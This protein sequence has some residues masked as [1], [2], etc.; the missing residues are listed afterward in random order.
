MNIR[1]KQA[2]KRKKRPSPI[3]R[4]TFIIILL[5]AAGFI[6]F[7]NI[8]N[9]NF[10]KNKFSSLLND[11][12]S[13]PAVSD[14]PETDTG[15]LSSSSSVEESVTGGDSDANEKEIEDD[16]EA[17]AGES[18]E[19][20]QTESGLSLWQKIRNFFTNQKDEKE[21]ESSYPNQLEVNFY[22]SADGNQTDAGM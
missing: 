11:S 1:N 22:F 3:L 21:N 15:Q 9:P 20:N 10:V 14:L 5:V 6:I 2:K 17:T 16:V 7:Y 13:E 18:S 19:D 12:E 4:F 8:D